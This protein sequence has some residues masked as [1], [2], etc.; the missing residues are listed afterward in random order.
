MTPSS[1]WVGAKWQQLKVSLWLCVDGV[2]QLGALCP[3]AAL[4]AV[5]H[6]Q[7]MKQSV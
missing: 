3:S 4:A 7:G 5:E 1:F 6:S 2:K